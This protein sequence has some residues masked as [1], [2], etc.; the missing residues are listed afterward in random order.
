M[1]CQ[2]CGKEIKKLDKYCGNC[3]CLCCQ[4]CVWPAGKELSQCSYF[5][6]KRH[7]SKIPNKIITI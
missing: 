2:N 7:I 1:K 4:L 5:P 6:F 3:G